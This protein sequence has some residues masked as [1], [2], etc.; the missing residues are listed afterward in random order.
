MQYFILRKI[1]IWGKDEYS[2]E[3]KA[4][5]GYDSITEVTEKKVALETLNDSKDVSYVIVNNGT[6]IEFMSDSDDNGNNA[7]ITEERL[8]ENN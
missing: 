6:P 2:I 1:K 3:A 5:H 7:I 8:A 4:Q